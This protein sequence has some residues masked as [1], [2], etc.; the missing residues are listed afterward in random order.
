VIESFKANKSFGAYANPVEDRPKD[1]STAEDGKD[2]SH[3]L[4]DLT[5][6]V[7]TNPGISTLVTILPLTPRKPVTLRQATAKSRQ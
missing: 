4:E 7:C 2:V 6:Y 1:N 3:S 5:K